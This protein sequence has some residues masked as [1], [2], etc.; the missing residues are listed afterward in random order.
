MLVLSFSFSQTH[1]L[2]LGHIFFRRSDSDLG[3]GNPSE[4]S[5]R[6]LSACT[7]GFII[8]GAAI[9]VPIGLFAPLLFSLALYVCGFGC[10]GVLAA[11][12][13]CNC[14]I[15]ASVMSAIHPVASGS[16]YACKFHQITE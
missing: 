1:F 4:K 11:V 16:T 14:S 9:G 3:I 6:M 8:K 10:G 7:I 5:T 15:A 13:C 12:C 2:I